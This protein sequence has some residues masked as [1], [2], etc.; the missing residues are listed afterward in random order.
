MKTVLLSLLIAASAF[1][2]VEVP[3]IGTIRDAA[4]AWHAVYG[5]AGNFVLGPETAEPEPIELDDVLAKLGV[6]VSFTTEELVLRRSD[7]NEVRF[8]VAGVER[9]RAMSAEYVQVS[10]SGREYVLRLKPGKEGLYLLPATV[11]EV[12]Q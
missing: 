4:G 1:A 2:Q 3:S 9:L 12:S 11:I 10:A 7:G 5:V 6:A 8:A